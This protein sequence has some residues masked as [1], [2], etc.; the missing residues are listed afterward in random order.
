MIQMS[1]RASPGP[2]AAFQ[3]HCSQRD[4]LTSEPFSSAKQ[5]VGSWK[6]SVWI[7]AG[8]DGFCGPKSCQKR[9]VS[10]SSGSIVTRNFSLLERAADLAPVGKRLQRVEALADVAVHLAV[11]HHL[12]G[13]DDVV[14]VMSSLGSQS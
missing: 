2:S 6:T 13:A 5:V 1:E 14:A 11:R 4:E 12:E 8:S 3:C 7:V 9:E 10:V